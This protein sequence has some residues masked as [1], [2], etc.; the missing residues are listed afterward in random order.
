MTQLSHIDCWPPS[1]LSILSPNRVGSIQPRDVC[2]CRGGEG[3]RG[4]VQEDEGHLHEAAGGTR[5]PAENGQSVV[6]GHMTLT[7][8]T[9]CPN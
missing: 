6:T 1:T 9:F 7:F 3:K 5:Q 8:S 4:E 2:C